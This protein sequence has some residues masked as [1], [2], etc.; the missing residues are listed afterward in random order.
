M[1]FGKRTELNTRTKI[2]IF[3][4]KKL[5]SA[6]TIVPLCVF[7]KKYHPSVS[8]IY[9]APDQ[10]TQNLIAQNLL[11][12]AAIND[13][14]EIRLLRSN[15]STSSQKCK[16]ILKFCQKLL[17]FWNISI[18]ALDI[19]C[20][21]AK[22]FHFGFWEHSKL[23]WFANL[24]NK[25]FVFF[26]KNCWGTNRLAE[27]ADN[28]MRERAVNSNYTTTAHYVAFDD[29]WFKYVRAKEKGYKTT[30]LPS[31]RLLPEWLHY[32]DELSENFVLSELKFTQ[33]IKK[34][35]K[36]F[37]I[38]LSAF[39]VDMT[40]ESETVEKYFS[41]TLKFLA[42]S[43]PE[44]PVFV[45]PHPVLNHELIQ[46]LINNSEHKFCHLTDMHSAVLGKIC[47]IVICNFFSFSITDAWAQG[48]RTIE[49]TEYAPPVS[50][51]LQ[52]KSWRNEFIDAF[53]D[54]DGKLF[55]QSVIRLLF[56]GKKNRNLQR[57]NFCGVSE[58]VND[59]IKL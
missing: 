59:I 1:Q 35:K 21:S 36:I 17:S 52:G 23:R 19:L 49:Y 4:S 29:C 6:D 26:Q 45:K 14:G 12:T 48:S 37:G 18:I 54:G 11:L 9:I 33:K 28:V 57:W 51:I 53:V 42:H 8:I 40:A 10:K 58:S 55:E 56:E 27:R 7:V 43:Y 15:L 38:V 41:K 24:K 47:D 16:F 34:S 5:I 44:S 39:H 30:Q 31:T 46:S 2:Y 13:T 50:S 3:L 20:G 25:N 32:V 22:V